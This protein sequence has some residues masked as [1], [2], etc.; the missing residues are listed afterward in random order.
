MS[1]PEEKKLKK[2]KKTEE[3]QNAQP[4]QSNI[5][6]PIV[7]VT[8]QTNLNTYQPSKDMSLTGELDIENKVR[9]FV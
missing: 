7:T 8:E 1:C 3:L 4:K 9:L 2:A 6:E 5:K